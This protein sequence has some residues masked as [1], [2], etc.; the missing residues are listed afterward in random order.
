MQ[1]LI[2]E[3]VARLAGTSSQAIFH[4]KQAMGGGK[5]HL[6]VGLGLL[7]RLPEL[8]KTY[9][10]GWREDRLHGADNETRVH[11]RRNEQ[12]LGTGYSA[13]RA[14]HGTRHAMFQSAKANRESARFMR[15]ET[16]VA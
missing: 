8:R 5:T 7:A 16:R 11:E 13:R 3:G 9:C 15:P 1:D 4:L 2:S 6:L 12:A 14:V 10:A